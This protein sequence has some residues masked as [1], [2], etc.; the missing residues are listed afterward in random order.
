MHCSLITTIQSLYS[1]CITPSSFFISA[2]LHVFHLPLLLPFVIL[3][4]SIV[5]PPYWNKMQCQ[6]TQKHPGTG[7][8]FEN[9]VITHVHYDR[10]QMMLIECSLYYK[11]HLFQNCWD[12]AVSTPCRGRSHSTKSLL[13]FSLLGQFLFPF[14]A[15][16]S[17]FMD[18]K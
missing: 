11:S 9:T 2:T 13:S 14:S 18:R 10:L 5:F 17:I 6:Q 1:F 8:F 4:F 3:T 12:V 15:F 7:W 16:H